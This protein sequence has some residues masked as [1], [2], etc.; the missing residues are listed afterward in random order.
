MSWQPRFYNARLSCKVR[1]LEAMAL[2]G[3]AGLS[4]EDVGFDEGVFGNARAVLSRQSLRRQS[5]PTQRQG[6]AK[7]GPRMMAAPKSGASAVAV[8]QWT[9]VAVAYVEVDRSG[10]SGR[11]VAFA[12]GI[13]GGVASS[14]GSITDVGGGVD[15]TIRPPPTA[16][17]NAEGQ[18]ER[19]WPW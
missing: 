6:I 19:A 17:H 11:C 3:D 18:G 2:L 10:G 14:S 9:T 1:G 13:D 5:A 12:S 8:P 15:K 4:V 16:G 7:S